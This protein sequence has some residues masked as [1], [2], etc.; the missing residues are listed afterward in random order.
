M[1][2]RKPRE[3]RLDD[4]HFI[5]MRVHKWFPEML[6]MTVLLASAGTYFYGSYI[7]KTTG[8]DTS[9]NFKST[10]KKPLKAQAKRSRHISSHSEIVNPKIIKTNTQSKDFDIRV[11]SV[12]ISDN[13]ASVTYQIINLGKQALSGTT[14]TGGEGEKKSG[15]DAISWKAKY[16]TV[17]QAD[18]ALEPNEKKELMIHVRDN[19]AMTT[20][21]YR[22][23]F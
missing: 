14:W 3:I 13:K 6:L 10:R 2:F 18:V 11:S 16:F 4:S 5:K 23:R 15:I 1:K 20:N 7:Y 12:N 8:L 22:V 17:K 19:Q 21:S 9:K